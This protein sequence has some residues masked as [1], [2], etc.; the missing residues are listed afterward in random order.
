MFINVCTDC[1]FGCFESRLLEEDFTLLYSKEC[2]SSSL[3]LNNSYSVC[4][5]YIE[6]GE[7]EKHYNENC[8]RLVDGT[9][10]EKQFLLI[11][12][13]F[14][15]LISGL[16]IVVIGVWMTKYFVLKLETFVLTMFVSP[17]FL[18]VV[19]IRVLNV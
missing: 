16:C 8:I 7:C 6:D 10:A 5:K 14:K 17:K 4:N 13:F 9:C 1:L 15:F 12:F 19:I 11:F 2:P 18:G 3:D